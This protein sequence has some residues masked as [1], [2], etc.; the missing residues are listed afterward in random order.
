VSVDSLRNQEDLKKQRETLP[1]PT[2]GPNRS[3]TSTRVHDESFTM[4]DVMGPKLDDARN[5]KV[6]PE[7]PVQET[8]AVLPVLS[9]SKTVEVKVATSPSTPS[10][11]PVKSTPEAPKITVVRTTKTLG[12]LEKELEQQKARTPKPERF[13]KKKKP[14]K[15]KDRSDDKPY[16]PAPANNPESLNP[17]NFMKIYDDETTEPVAATPVPEVEEAEVEVEDFDEYYEEEK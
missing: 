9:Q 15:K 16:T 4:E 6:S 14:F 12:E 2:Q 7:T 17:A 11:A 13:D 3:T 1:N 8:K 5:E 10:A